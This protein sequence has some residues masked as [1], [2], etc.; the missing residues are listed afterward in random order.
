MG[1]KK[2]LQPGVQINPKEFTVKD[3]A[4]SLGLFQ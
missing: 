1:T 4:E 3:L 2:N